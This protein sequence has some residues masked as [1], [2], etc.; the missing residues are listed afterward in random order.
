MLRFSLAKR[1]ILTRKHLGSEG[2]AQAPRS[3]I[4]GSA[5]HRIQQAFESSNRLPRRLPITPARA[6]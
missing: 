4:A 3:G 5:D 1:E 6:G 2:E